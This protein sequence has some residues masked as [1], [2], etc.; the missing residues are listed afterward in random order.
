ML[1]MSNRYC[2]K[3]GNKLHNEDSFCTKCGSKKIKIKENAVTKDTKQKK[4]FNLNQ[5]YKPLCIV[6]LI[7]II[8]FAFI[9]FNQYQKNQSL[10]NRI[11]SLYLE[12]ENIESELNNLI[13]EVDNLKKDINEKDNTIKYQEANIINLNYLIQQKEAEIESLKIEI[14][15][16]EN[17]LANTKKDLSKTTSLYQQAK[18]YEERVIQG[19][20]IWLAYQLLDDYEDYAQPIILDYLGLS[21]PKKPVNN[22]E[23]W[24]RGKQVYNWLSDN[25]YY[26]GDRGLRVE[27]TFNEFQFSSPDEMLI[28]DN[29]RCGDCD[30]YAFLFAGLM[31]ASGVSEN[32]VWVV[33]GTVPAGGHCWNWIVLDNT[34][35]IVDPVCSEKEDRFKFLNFRWSVQNTKYSDTPK[36][37]GCFESYES[38][39]RMNPKGTINIK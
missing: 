27:N 5:I 12:K 4:I 14:R 20:N 34:A 35:Y 39:M 37:I 9:T 13:L 26:C 31:Y 32:D 8:F 15:L 23:L 18:P 38:Y 17:E 25:Y 3:C 19:Q 28:S 2:T 1:K 29:A 11:N 24:E 30:N 22:Q 36:N 10:N 7:L 16:I 33:C 21:Q 6:F